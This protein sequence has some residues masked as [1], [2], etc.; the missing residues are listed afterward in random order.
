VTGWPVAPPGSLTEPGVTPGPWAPD[1][2]V[3]GDDGTVYVHVWG[4]DEGVSVAAF[5]RTGHLR[6]GWPTQVPSD[7]PVVVAPDDRPYVVIGGSVALPAWDWP[8]RVDCLQPLDPAGGLPFLG[9]SYALSPSE[10]K[11]D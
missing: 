5:D 1:P 4:V 11:T 3:F 2:P 8:L 7:A 9:C 10:G 6:P